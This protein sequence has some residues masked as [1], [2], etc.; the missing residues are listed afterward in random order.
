MD[1]ISQTNILK[2]IF[3]NENVWISIKTSLRFAPRGPIN[4]IPALVQ[5]MAWCRPGDKPL[6]VPMVVSLQMH[7][8]VTRPQWVTLLALGDVAVILKV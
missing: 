2:Y 1:V 6:S 5:M 7:L 4:N 3:L 8:R